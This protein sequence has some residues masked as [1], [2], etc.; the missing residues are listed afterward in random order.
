MTYHFLHFISNKI[1]KLIYENAPECTILKWTKKSKNFC[2]G[3]GGRHLSPHPSYRRLD[4]STFGARPPTA[5][6]TD[7]TLPSRPRFMPPI[8]KLKSW[9]RPWVGLSLQIG[10]NLFSGEHRR[11]HRI[12]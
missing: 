3:R 2:G 11:M 6:L 12:V 9:I 5:F 4:S 8:P 1:L 7:R 10:R